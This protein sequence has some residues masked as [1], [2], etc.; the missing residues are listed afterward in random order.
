VRVSVP[1]ALELASLGLDFGARLLKC[2]GR[3]GTRLGINLLLKLR[4]IALQMG[5]LRLEVPQF[6]LAC[7]EFLV[8]YAL[9]SLK[10]SKLHLA[11][12]I[13]LREN[14]C[15]LAG[16]VYVALRTLELGRPR[17][18]VAVQLRGVVLCAYRERCDLDIALRS[19]AL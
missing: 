13:V 3:H 2:H 10:R 19:C 12:L 11:V 5:E 14:S 8:G 9:G 4:R 7:G 6:L 15:A 16:L 17:L 18:Q 1:Q